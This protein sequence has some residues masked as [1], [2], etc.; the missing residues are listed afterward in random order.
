MNKKHFALFTAAALAIV[1]RA[2]ELFNSDWRFFLGG[3]DK[4]AAADFDDASWRQ[5]DLPHDFQL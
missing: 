4:C 3:G 1:A 5:L 2:D